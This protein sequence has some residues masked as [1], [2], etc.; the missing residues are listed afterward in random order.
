MT[1]D[2]ATVRP[3]ALVGSNIQSVGAKIHGSLAAKE[4]K[5][6]KEQALS[7]MRSLRSFAAKRLDV[8]Q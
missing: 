4:R 1:D 5:E 2:A 7:S 6:R 3:V 8:W